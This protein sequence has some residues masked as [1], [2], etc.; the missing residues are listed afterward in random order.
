MQK[1]SPQYPGFFISIEGCEGSGK[2]T[3]ARLLSEW[4]QDK[5][6]RRVLQTREP[7]GTAIG[8]QLRDII[9][10]PGVVK[11]AELFL[12]AADRVQHVET[13]LL[14]HL[15]DGYIVV[16]DRY[17]DSTWAYQHYGRGLPYAVVSSLV[18]QSSMGLSPDLTI[19]I[20]LNTTDGLLRKSKQNDEWTK[21]EGEDARFHQAVYSGFKTI[22]EQEPSRFIVVDGGNPVA[23]IQE[24][25]RHWVEIRLSDNA[26]V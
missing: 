25:I 15:H 12:Y 24:K 22:A 7:G 4:L 6:G 1:G 17:S 5:H 21:F 19:L 18:A 11:M 14:P 23:S 2:T 8:R 10:Q 9:F 13:L 16:C 3:Q 26:S 20:D